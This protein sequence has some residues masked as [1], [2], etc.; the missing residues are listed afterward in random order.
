MKITVFNGSP[1]AKL[2]N[3][4]VIVENFL[5]GARQAGAEAEQVYLAKYKIN[6][7]RGCKT[8]WEK[9]PGKCAQKDDM[10]ELIDKVIS[11]DVMGFATPVYADNVSGTLKNFIDRLIVIG[12]P[13]WVK[14]EFGECR[15]V[16]RYEKPNRLLV[17]SN[18]GFPEQSHFQVLRLL[19]K[20]MAR[21]LGWSIMGE[22]YRAGGA[23]LTSKDENTIPFIE[24]YKQ[25]LKKAGAE[26]VEQG[27]IS[28]ETSAEL[29][30]PLLPIPNFTDVFFRRV[31]QIC[32]EMDLRFK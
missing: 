2:G 24:K 16:L 11:S 4:N 29:E 6:P 19:F 27:R 21:N 8:C 10:A 18:C 12:D 20:R 32:D 3:T 25:L 7:C 17:F 26:A 14:D 31:N 9:T 5:E 22:V 28:E 1:R 15:H 13:H 23:L 30:K